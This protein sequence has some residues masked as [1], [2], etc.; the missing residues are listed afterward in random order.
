[1]FD[2]PCDARLTER[3]DRQLRKLRCLCPAANPPRSAHTTQIADRLRCASRLMGTD[4][5]F[6]PCRRSPI[7]SAAT[8]GND[9]QRNVAPRF[10]VTAALH[11]RISPERICSGS[12][13][14]TLSAV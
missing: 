14:G 5:F 2:F 10:V 12:E 6:R 7:S 11:V 1:M 13:I 4:Q 3:I 9:R 8:T